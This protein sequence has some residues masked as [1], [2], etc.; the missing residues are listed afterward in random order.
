[1]QD[2][3]SPPESSYGDFHST[4]RDK[5]GV[6]AVGNPEDVVS[7]ASE[8]TTLFPAAMNYSTNDTD[9]P[10]LLEFVATANGDSFATHSR[11]EALS[12]S[13][14]L[15]SSPLRTPFLA[16]A[17]SPLSSEK[18]VISMH[19]SFLSPFDCGSSFSPKWSRKWDERGSQ[20]STS[21]IIIRGSL[22]PGHRQLQLLRIP[23]FSPSTNPLVHDP[24]RSPFAELPLSSPGHNV[25]KITPLSSQTYTAQDQ[26]H[27]HD[28]HMS[29]PKL[30]DRPGLLR[31]LPHFTVP[32]SPP[33]SSS[34]VVPSSPACLLTPL[35][36]P[37]LI[38]SKDESK[39][40]KDTSY[41]TLCSSS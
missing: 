6:M 29:K 16:H 38:R 5:L 2:H 36:S 1:M 15:L 18:S 20:V 28:D 39:L 24:H 4:I 8:L 23:E 10:C 11:V 40:R 19:S 26:L 41:F 17:H 9:E 27:G 33:F 35:R 34:P 14:E 32:M 37:F 12:V 31:N 13:L 30:R 25:P 21:P 22:N 3:W 7:G